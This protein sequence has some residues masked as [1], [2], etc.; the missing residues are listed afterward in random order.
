MRGVAPVDSDKSDGESDGSAGEAGED[1]R[2]PRETAFG[3][4]TADSRPGRVPDVTDDGDSPAKSPGP[5]GDDER[6]SPNTEEQ[7]DGPTTSIPRDELQGILGEPDSEQ[8]D[9][10]GATTSIERDSLDRLVGD[11]DESAESTSSDTATGKNESLKREEEP[12]T[13]APNPNESAIPTM[14]RGDEDDSSEEPDA[15]ETAER[16]VDDADK[17]STRFGMP[18]VDADDEDRETSDGGTPGPAP[19]LSPSSSVSKSDE[20]ATP[21]EIEGN[22]RE[23][24]ERDASPVD[25]SAQKK[26]PVDEHEGGDSPTKTRLGMSAASNEEAA[27]GG[28]DSGPEAAEQEAEPFN[29]KGF[30]E[31]GDSQAADIGPQD[32]DPIEP[33]QI[34][35][36]GTDPTEGDESEV[37]DPA[38]DGHEEQSEEELWSATIDEDD[39]ENSELSESSDV[40]ERETSPPSAASL[41]EESEPDAGSSR[42][43]RDDDFEFESGP[44]DDEVSADESGGSATPAAK[45][46]GIIRPKNR[47]SNERDPSGEPSQNQRDR[48]SGSG[49]IGGGTYMVRGDG[50]GLEDDCDLE[51]VDP[52]GIDGDEFENAGLAGGEHEGGSNESESRGQTTDN[53]APS[54]EEAGASASEQ[55][56]SHEQFSEADEEIPE[57]RPGSPAP[58]E[59]DRVIDESASDTSSTDEAAASTGNGQEQKRADS[60]V[61]PNSAPGTTARAARPRKNKRPPESQQKTPPPTAETSRS[62]EARPAAQPANQ[63]KLDRKLVEIGQSMFGTVAGVL[64][65]GFAALR[66]ITAGPSPLDV[67]T[68][69][70]GIGGL[71]VVAAP[72]V[73]IGLTVRSAILW[74]VGLGVLI[75]VP[76]YGIDSSFQSQ[77][78]LG[79]LGGALT[80]VA[81]LFPTVVQLLESLGGKSDGDS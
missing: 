38:S 35:D 30:Q 7:G 52:G 18:A 2:D 43:P 33:P 58:P 60:N 3:M 36:P 80:L 67:A 65:I 78:V 64:L 32:S 1:E 72:F 15:R 71:T 8:E 59:S 42:E 14:H 31:T 13:S 50:E 28:F 47:S 61:S 6:S 45:A 24:A 57:S 11:L 34:D 77:H 26:P 12:P 70:C 55:M 79:V 5:D 73:P 75:V 49:L 53:A 10:G 23:T 25:S 41:F 66:L 74:V 16:S 22:E 69:V 81:G 39:S 37:A 4:P 19:G 21:G 17:S 54:A 76:L 63:Q 62:A 56:G 46:S 68:L 9:P 20:D 27:G 44:P 51:E 48:E 40:H 29:I